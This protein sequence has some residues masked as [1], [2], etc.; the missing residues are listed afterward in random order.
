MNLINPQ[1]S[2]INNVLDAFEDIIKRKKI[3]FQSSPPADIDKIKLFEISF[4]V[5]LPDSFKTFLEHFNGG[6]IADEE[7]ENLLLIDEFEE[8]KKISTQL[9]GI[10]E[11]IEEYENLSLENWDRKPGF[12]GF[13]PFIPFCITNYG[14][15]LVFVDQYKR[16]KESGVF[17]ASKN[18]EPNQWNMINEDF[19]GFLIG[20][21]NSMGSPPIHYSEGGLMADDYLDMLNDR[22]EELND[23]AERIKR[24]SAYLKIFPNDP[25]SY[26]SRGTAYADMHQYDN[27]LSDFNKSLE[28]NEKSAFTYY[29]RGD[30]F[31]KVRKPRQALIDLDIACNLS[32]DDPFYLS[33]RANAFYQLN[34]MDEALVDCNRTLEI[35]DTYLQAYEVRRLIY[36]YL[37]EALKAEKDAERINELLE[38]DE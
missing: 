34:R 18:R 26:T 30:M 23:P 16:E 32:P 27:A 12:K 35:N 1:L 4:G 21:I 37:G 38:N 29:C 11:I 33:S 14:E 20:N 6:F 19:T 5:R 3:Y 2:N 25:I 24:N 7:A 15:M 10:D 8:A 13:Y 28:L 22:E 31:L 36:L 17:Y 9:L